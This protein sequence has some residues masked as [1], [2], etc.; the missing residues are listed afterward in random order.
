MVDSKVIRIPRDAY[1]QAKKMRDTLLKKPSDGS[2]PFAIIATAGVSAFIGG[3]LG[4]AIANIEKNK[5][6]VE[7]K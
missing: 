1:E 5:K 6:K 3:L 2:D 7:E 4:Y